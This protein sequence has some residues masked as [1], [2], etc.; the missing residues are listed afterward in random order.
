[1]KRVEVKPNY[2]ARAQ[3]VLPKLEKGMRPE[4]S[5]PGEKFL[6]GIAGLRAGSDP[7]FDALDVHRDLLVTIQVGSGVIVADLFDVVAVPVG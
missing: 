3:K 6:Y 5:Y 2:Q 4:D 7:V 1:M